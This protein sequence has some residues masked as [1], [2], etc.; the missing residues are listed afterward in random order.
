[1]KKFILLLVVIAVVTS[2]LLTFYYL[3]KP[4]KEMS[5]AEKQT[6]I[7]KILGRKPNMADNVKT[8]DTEYKGKYVSFIY[9]AAGVIYIQKLNGVPIEQT[10]LEY[11]SFDLS[12]PKLVF[13]MEVVQVPGSVTSLEDY[14]SVKLREIESNLYVKNN[15]AVGDKE[16]MV[17][18]KT[19][20]NSFEKSVFF[21]LGD[22]VFSF[23]IS[24]NDQK[25]INDLYDKVI[26]SLKFL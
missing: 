9:P 23:V 17:F 15:V 14:P 22:K 12:E 3:N 8:G 19:D 13:S 20:N 25:G 16:G 7:A 4:A 11:F 26:S 18:E 2:V 1:M 24:G 10:S 21:Y 5:E 6:A